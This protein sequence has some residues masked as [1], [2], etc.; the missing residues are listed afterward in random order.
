MWL[1][2][3]LA[4]L[5]MVVPDLV[6]RSAALFFLITLGMLMFSVAGLVGLVGV[7]WRWAGTLA[8]RTLQAVV[9]VMVGGTALSVMASLV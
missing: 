8:V 9:A 4:N 2:V 3:Q 1:L 6:R 7:L 5:S